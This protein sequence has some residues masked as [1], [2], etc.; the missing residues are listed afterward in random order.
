M[1]ELWER[2]PE[3]DNKW[4]DRFERYR[5]MGINRSFLG[6]YTQEKRD[7]AAQQG[8]EFKQPK[9]TPGSWTQHIIDYQWETRAHAWDEHER[10]LRVKEA[11]AR[12][13]NEVA[14]AREIMWTSLQALQGIAG[15]IINT[16]GEQAKHEPDKIDLKGFKE[17]MLGFGV[18]MKEARLTFGEPTDR[19]DVTSGGEK[20]AWESIILPAMMDEDDI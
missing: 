2:L 5:L 9:S 8:H 19:T 10:Q 11:D 13:A 16:M 18:I 14:K 7:R 15:R 4:W 17:F 20:I 1:A 6:V 3:E 12:R